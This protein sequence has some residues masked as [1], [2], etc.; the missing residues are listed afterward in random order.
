[1][2]EA[3]KPPHPLA[4]LGGLAG[5]AAGWMFSKYTGVS[6]WI[7]ISAVVLLLLVFSRTSLKP[8]W[9]VGAITMTLA[10]VIWFI[11]V[12]AVAGVWAAVISDI[13]VLLGLAV[14]LWLRPGGFTASLLGLVQ[15]AS[16]AHNVYF[17]M[18]IP[19][20]DNAH[21]GLTAHI[22]LRSIAL[23]TLVRGYLKYRRE[24]TQW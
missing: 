14:L 11:V 7:P 20:G 19:F 8:K 24:K 2:S 4:F 15:V 22:V 6:G 17:I 13:V 12:G 21:R 5:A 9:F 18:Q 3:P 16:L 1:M 10:Q 23:V